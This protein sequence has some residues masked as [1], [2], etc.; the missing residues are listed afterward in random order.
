MSAKLSPAIKKALEWFE[1]RPDGA[2]MFSCLEYSPSPS[3]RKR[4]VEAGLVEE[5][6]PQGWGLITFRITPAGRAAL[7]QTQEEKP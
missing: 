6:R 3:T 7:S 1:G 5:I 4:L 2:S